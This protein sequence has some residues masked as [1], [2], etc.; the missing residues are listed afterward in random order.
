MRGDKSMEVAKIREKMER[1]LE[2][3]NNYSTKI[4]ATNRSPDSFVLS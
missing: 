2:I 3:H 1:H 4:L